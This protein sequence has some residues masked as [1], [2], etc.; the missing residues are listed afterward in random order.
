[1]LVEAIHSVIK[2]TYANL[3]II[4]GNDNPER[5]LSLGKLGIPEDNRIKIINHP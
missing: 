5:N 2:Q 1:M 4:I 3:E